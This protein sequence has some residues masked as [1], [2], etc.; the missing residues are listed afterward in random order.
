MFPAARVIN[1]DPRHSD[2]RPV[3]IHTTVEDD[4]QQHGGAGGGFRF[5]AAWV[6]EERCREIIKEAWAASPGG[7]GGVR[8]AE[9]LKSVAGSLSSWSTNVLGDMEKTVKRLKEL[10]VCRRGVSSKENIE[11]E[12]VLRYRLEKVEDQI[13]SY[14]RQRAHVKWMQHGDRN[15]AFFHACML[16]EEKKQ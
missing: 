16:G 9:A 4:P 7:A 8:V 10:E 6:D 11:K 13:D 1:G 3:I 15:T 2:H 12:G 14:W 5:E